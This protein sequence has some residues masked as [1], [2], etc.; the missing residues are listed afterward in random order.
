MKCRFAFRGRE[1]QRHGPEGREPEQIQRPK[2]RHFTLG[3]FAERV[4]ERLP[5]NEDQRIRFQPGEDAGRRAALAAEMDGPG[6]GLL[7]WPGDEVQFRREPGRSQTE[8][9]LL[10]FVRRRRYARH[11]RIQQSGREPGGLIG[12]RGE[13]IGTEDVPD[14]RFPS[15]LHRGFFPGGDLEAPRRRHV[16]PEY[17]F[18]PKVPGAPVE[19]VPGEGGR[20]Q[21]PF[22]EL[23]VAVAGRR[24]LVAESGAERF[25]VRLEEQ[26]DRESGWIESESGEVPFGRS[27]D[28]P[29]EA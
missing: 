11:L 2:T 16:Q 3:R 21:H 15:D 13:A 14:A 9:I 29:L 22:A 17:P 8:G 1:P 20:H 28:L 19:V 5:G 7:L 27:F 23:E 24:G 6:D 4:E 18:V 25:A 12:V 26:P 10:T